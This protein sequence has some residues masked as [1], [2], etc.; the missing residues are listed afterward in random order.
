MRNLRNEDNPY[1]IGVAVG[2]NEN[3]QF[4]DKY[5]DWYTRVNQF[6]ELQDVLEVVVDV[7]GTVEHYI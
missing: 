1:I 5:T 2:E 6:G 4:M 3:F 7:V